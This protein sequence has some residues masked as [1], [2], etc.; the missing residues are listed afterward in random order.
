M[1]LDDKRTQKAFEDNLAP[2]IQELKNFPWDDPRC[3]ANWLAQSYYLVLH[4]TTFLS[5][6]AAKFGADNL[7]RHRDVLK[8]LREEFGH[9]DLALRDLKAL[10]FGITDFPELMETSLLYQSQYY[11]L[12]RKGPVAHVGYSL[13]LEGLAVRE[14]KQLLANIDRLHGKDTSSF[15]RVHA[16]DDVGHFAEGMRRLNSAS[17]DGI[18]QA[19]RNLEQSRH[20]YASILQAIARAKAPRLTAKAA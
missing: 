12:E 1:K 15:I 17:P 19:L 6:V 10:G 14:G 16:M 2:L 13:M 3:Y 11:W 8:H 4:T 9:E 7:E 5:L 18:A 20:L